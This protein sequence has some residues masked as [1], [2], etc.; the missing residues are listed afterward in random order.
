MSIVSIEFILLIAGT[1][2]VYYL[3]PGRFQW[4]V[5]LA[6]SGVFYSVLGWQCALWVLGTASTVYLATVLMSRFPK[7]SAARK[8]LCV[9]TA[10]VNIAALALF[11]YFPLPKGLIMP[12]GISFYTFQSL[13]YL[14]D[15]YH[16]SVPAEKN[17]LKTLLFVCFFPQMT[18]GPISDF[19]Q[20]SGQ[21]YGAHSF[22]YD[23]FSRGTQRLLWGFIKKIMLADRL[24]VYV[25]ALFAHYG[26]L[27]GL[28]VLVGI[29]IYAIWLYADFSGYMDIVCGSCDLLDIRLA[30]NFRQ[31]YFSHS[32]AEY[33][34][35]WHIT[36]GEWMKKYIYYP[37]A[38]SR[39]CQKL[40]RVLRL[41]SRALAGNTVGTLALLVTWAATGIWHGN[42]AGYIV[43]GLINGA[44]L[45]L[46]LW[47]ER[48]YAGAKKT[49]HIRDEA[50]WWRGFTLV[51]TFIIVAFIKI[52]PEVGTLGDGVGLWAR[53]FTFTAPASLSELA[54]AQYG[55]TIPAATLLVGLL[56]FIC[57]IISLKYD[58][59]SLFGKL[60][61]IVRIVILAGALLILVSVGIPEDM[62]E[63]GFAYARF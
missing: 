62:A 4:V 28:S 2:L 36:L 10:L 51:R 23:N 43:W 40:G 39:P 15:V 61:W 16:G 54:L 32:V 52:L 25:R 47:L 21:L 29:F 22:S 11:K 30:E 42:T 33:W 26:E 14:T 48:A 59:R 60:P 3:I 7:K 6:A 41:R 38:A 35:R 12:L 46:S 49:L 8:A 31:P 19:R 24:S 1:V 58:V 56:F 57:S 5:L 27:P 44:F 34:R 63:G 53:A 18:Q 13:G 50:W 17:Y 45:I 55:V 20:L 9:C 37:V